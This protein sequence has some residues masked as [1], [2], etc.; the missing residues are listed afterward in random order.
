MSYIKKYAAFPIHEIYKV[1]VNEDDDDITYKAGNF[2]VMECELRKE[3]KE[4]YGD[5]SIC[6][7]Y[8]VD[9]PYEQ[10]L[11]DHNDYLGKTSK[12]N[13][14]YVKEV[15]DTFEDAKRIYYIFKR[16]SI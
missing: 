16:K 10:R 8:A 2:I 12:G 3:I 1:Y 6:K 11:S 5:G 4:Y 9:F 14:M 7:Y 13:Y 15:F